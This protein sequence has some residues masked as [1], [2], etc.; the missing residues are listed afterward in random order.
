MKTHSVS[1]LAPTPAGAGGCYFDFP[2]RKESW[3]MPGLKQVIADLKAENKKLKALLKNAVRLLNQSKKFLRHP[4]KP[5]AE[6]KLE[7]RKKA[8]KPAKRQTKAAAR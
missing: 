5:A 1:R 2:L 3:K 7:A 6:N 8:K 4:G